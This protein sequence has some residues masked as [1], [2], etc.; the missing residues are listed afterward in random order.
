M[1]SG[2]AETKSAESEE[3]HEGVVL[4][5]DSPSKEGPIM[6]IRNVHKTYLLGIGALRLPPALF[7]PHSLPRALSDRMVT[8]ASAAEGVPALRGVSL[9]IRRGEFV[10]IVRLPPSGG[11]APAPA[12]H[13]ACTS[14]FSPAAG[15]VGP[16]FPRSWVKAAA[17][18]LL[19]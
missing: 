9:S 4:R 7:A 5:V 17:E 8:V 14:H 6:R 15:G 13:R 16:S 12:R 1:A 2:A 11:L 18:R 3:K 19:C 10:V